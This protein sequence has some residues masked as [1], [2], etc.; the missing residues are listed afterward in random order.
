MSEPISASANFSDMLGLTTVLSGSLP[1]TLG[2]LDAPDKYQVDAVFT[3]RPTS[4]EVI[5]IHSAATKKALVAA[6]YPDV[7][8]RVSDRRLEIRDTTLE[9]LEMGL[10]TFLADYLAHITE[11]IREYQATARKLVEDAAKVEGSRSEAV[12]ARAALIRFQESGGVR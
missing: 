3:R 4:E 1:P 5:A 7:T 9:Q 10:A 2:T 8:L 11:E 12:A 6:G